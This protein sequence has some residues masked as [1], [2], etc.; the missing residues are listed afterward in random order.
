MEVHGGVEG[1]VSI[2]EGLPQEGDEVAA[3]GEQDVGVHEGDAG[4]RAP[5]EDDAHSGGV[6]DTHVVCCKGV[7]CGWRR[8]RPTVSWLGRSSTTGPGPLPSPPAGGRGRPDVFIQAGPTQLVAFAQGRPH[9]KA[10]KPKA[11]PQGLSVTHN[12]LHLQGHHLSP[13]PSPGWPS[14]TVGPLQEKRPGDGVEHRHAADVAS[15]VLDE[16]LELLHCLVATAAL[17]FL[18]VSLGEQQGLE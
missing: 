2:E 16:A 4:C 3:H 9:P 18:S 12:R 5:R 8:M 15:V 6:R 17:K 1:H 13:A 10:V 14:L 7:V 11:P